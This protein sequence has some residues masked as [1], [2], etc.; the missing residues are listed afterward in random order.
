M[1]F[2]LCRCAE[3]KWQRLSKPGMLV[4]VIEGVKFAD[5][6]ETMENAA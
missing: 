1:A 5:G 2:Q 4:K 3:K 6:V